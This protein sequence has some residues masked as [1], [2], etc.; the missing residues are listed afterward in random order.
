MRDL[1]TYLITWNPSEFRWDGLREDLKAIREGRPGDEDRWSTGNT[2]R[3]NSGDRLFMLKQGRKLPRGVMGS[4]WAK[5]DWFQD[6]HWN[7]KRA[8][9]G[10]IANYVKVEF[11]ALL[12]PDSEQLLGG[13][14]LKLGALSAV[15]WATPASGISVPPAAADEL[16]EMWARHIAT[17]RT[18]VDEGAFDDAGALEGEL[19]LRL[20]RH[21]QRERALRHRKIVEALAENDGHLPCEVPGCGFDFLD[22]YGAVGKRYAQVHHLDPVA[23]RTSPRKT[24]L[25]ELAIVCANCHAMIHVGGKSRPLQSVSPQSRRRGS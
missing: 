14:A 4:G 2:K 23:S 12:D 13:A 3:V 6:E 19:R 7:R 10:D 18:P 22:T 9:A 16:E 5:S 20:V 24:L 21:R 1:P 25:S 8:A 15:N 17:V 11:E